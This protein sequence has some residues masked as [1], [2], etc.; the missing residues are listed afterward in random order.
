MTRRITKPPKRRLLAH[1]EV[2]IFCHFSYPSKLE[3][4]LETFEQLLIETAAAG[5]TTFTE[6]QLADA[7]AAYIRHAKDAQY[8]LEDPD[9]DLRRLWVDALK[10]SQGS[11]RNICLLSPGAMSYVPWKTSTTTDYPINSALTTTLTEVLEY[12]CRY[13]STIA[14]DQLFSTVVSCLA[15]SGI[16]ITQI[17][18]RNFMQKPSLAQ[19]YQ[20][21]I[22]WT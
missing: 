19:K 22:F 21:G 13:A 1:C 5:K 8:L 11:L 3:A 18:I 15:T 17:S 9:S 6:S 7:Y 4:P 2:Y 16:A 12:G 20:A 10:V 14:G